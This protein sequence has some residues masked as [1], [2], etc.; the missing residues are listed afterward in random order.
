MS[1]QRSSKAKTKIIA[2][3]KS[4]PSKNVTKPKRKK[5]PE[6]KRKSAAKSPAKRLSKRGKKISYKTVK[7][8]KLPKKSAN[9]PKVSVS[10]KPLTKGKRKPVK[11]ATKTRIRGTLII[12]RERGKEVIK[13]SFKNVRDI[14]KKIALLESSLELEKAN[15][16]QLK[17]KGGKPPKGLIIVV[18]NKTGVETAHVTRPSFVSNQKNIL[19]EFRKYMRDL[20]QSHKL[21]VLQGRPKDDEMDESGAS[22]NPNSIESIDIK[23]IY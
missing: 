1:R 12:K 9:K 8:T 10:K 5:V 3:K 2:K 7:R 6:T 16:N 11:V 18:R 15:K 21:W 4:K 20:K 13:I 17:R 22:F 19:K 23:F 14:E